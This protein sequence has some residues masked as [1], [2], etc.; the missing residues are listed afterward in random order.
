M[1][2]CIVTQTDRPFSTLT[3]MRQSWRLFADVRVPMISPALSPWI[4]NYDFACVHDDI[5]TLM[6]MVSLCVAYETNL[7]IYHADCVILCASY[8]VRT[9]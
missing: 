5:Y 1:N 3:Y 2:I 7:F 9:Q 6:T 4:S 8:K